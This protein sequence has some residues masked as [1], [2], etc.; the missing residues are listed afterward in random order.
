MSVRYFSDLKSLLFRFNHFS[1]SDRSLKL[2]FVTPLDWLDFTKMKDLDAVYWYCMEEPP[3]KIP[4]DQQKLKM[5]AEPSI[6]LTV[7]TFYRL[8]FMPGAK[9]TPN[10]VINLAAFQSHLCSFCSFLLHVP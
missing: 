8:R 2:L 3:A 6:F 9:R 1:R 5:V 4:E 10:S 7:D